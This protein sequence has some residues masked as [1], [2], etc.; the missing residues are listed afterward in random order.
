MF[1]PPRDCLC[2][3]MAQ[4]FLSLSAREL[5]CAFIV[6]EFE[7]SGEVYYTVLCNHL[8]DAGW[9]WVSGRAGN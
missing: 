4:K 9:W 7:L 3:D 2:I 6:E 1:I 8:R 5:V